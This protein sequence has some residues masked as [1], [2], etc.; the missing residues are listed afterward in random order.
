[1]EWVGGYNLPMHQTVGETWSLPYKEDML[2]RMNLSSGEIYELWN[3]LGI[4]DSTG[5]TPRDPDGN[6]I[7]IPANYGP[8]NSY[9]E[10]YAR[11]M[12]SN[13][14]GNAPIGTTAAGYGNTAVSVAPTNR[15]GG[16]RKF[17]NTGESREDEL[18]N[19]LMNEQKR[20][21]ELTN[22]ERLKRIMDEKVGKNIV[23]DFFPTKYDQMCRDG[24]YGCAQTSGTL[25]ATFGF[26]KRDGTPIR[27]TAGTASFAN[28][29]HYEQQGYELLPRG[30]K[31]QP[32]DVWNKA[33]K[34]S[35]GIQGHQQTIYDPET[36]EV[37]HNPGNIRS[38]L[39]RG[40]MQNKGY[41]D[42]ETKAYRY[43]GYQDEMRK[44]LMDYVHDQPLK[45]IST[46]PVNS[47]AINLDKRPM[48]TYGERS[49]DNLAAIRLGQEVYLDG[50][51][52]EEMI[53]KGYKIQYF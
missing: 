46:K 9:E 33:T 7:D 14:L 34:P 43:T 35:K 17:K 48:E 3:Q 41:G 2:N 18:Y 37:V 1:M 15:Y 29:K 20:V 50:G 32:G 42:A 44:E 11:S 38:G 10:D 40:K 5:P 23:Q 21:A 8:Q 22:P 19:N 47:L 31:L 52:V 4:D 45:R 27:V 49:T 24:S 26:T 53:K 12:I 36:G 51:Q 25:G 30:A 6:L 13:A 28:P 16:L 39:L